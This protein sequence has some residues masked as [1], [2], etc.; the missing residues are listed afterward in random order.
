MF[1]KELKR[2]ICSNVILH[3]CV[4]IDLLIHLELHFY[5]MSL[6]ANTRWNQLGR[7]FQAKLWDVFESIS[8]FSGL[9]DIRS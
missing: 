1:L 2:A 4:L 3:N 5:A 9:V 6:S 8:E 7:S